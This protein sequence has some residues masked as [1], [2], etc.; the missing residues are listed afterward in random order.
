MEL[1]KP[2]DVTVGRGDLSVN[3]WF[4]SLVHS[5]A[6]CGGVYKPNKDRELGALFTTT[7]DSKH[8]MFCNTRLEKQ[9]V[10]YPVIYNITHQ[11]AMNTGVG[12]NL[13]EAR[14]HYTWKRK[15]PRHGK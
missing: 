7:T 13:D 4:C 6:K 3:Q 5:K 14:S 1:L 15:N 9:T 12:N 10:T 8:P 11:S 2:L